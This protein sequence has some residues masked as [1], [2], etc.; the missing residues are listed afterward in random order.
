VAVISASAASIV[1]LPQRVVLEALEAMSAPPMQHSAAS[2]AQMIQSILTRPTLSIVKNAIR[3]PGGWVG[4]WVGVGESSR[5]DGMVVGGFVARGVGGERETSVAV[6]VY[7]SAEWLPV[8]RR[9]GPNLHSPSTV[10]HPL[11]ST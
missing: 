3:A 1:P 7:V 6:W 10:P 11:S 5:G 8:A 2:T 4:G 9:A